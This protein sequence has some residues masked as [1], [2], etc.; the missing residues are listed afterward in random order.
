MSSKLRFVFFTSFS[1]SL[2]Y[3]HFNR[4]KILAESLIAKGNVVEIRL[5]NKN[6]T[7]NFQQKW[8]KYF[9]NKKKYPK[10]DVCIVDNYIY[11]DKFYL[12]LRKYYENIVIFDDIKFKVPKHVMGVINPNIYADKDNYPSNIKV[13]AGK[14]FI[15]LRKEFQRNIKKTNKKNI[16]L[17]LG[18]SDPTSQ[19]NRYIKI[20]L[21]NS[22]LKINAIFGHGYKNLQDINK[23]KKNERVNV[24]FNVKKISQLM[25]NS[26]FALSSS[27]SMLYELKS[28]NIPT[29]CIS[30]AKNQKLLGESMS[31]FNNID[32]LGYYKQLKKNKL[33]Q[34]IKKKKKKL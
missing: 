34:A 7:I 27:G 10:A 1:S 20:L 29:I 33:V 15:L 32:Y 28:L 30:L 19:M 18:G 11:E 3:G 21:Q 4:C 8:I 6:K 25:A 16:F 26:K 9:L 31:V 13:W 5:L 2:G 12:Y 22:K 23:W 17:C 24:F 14:K